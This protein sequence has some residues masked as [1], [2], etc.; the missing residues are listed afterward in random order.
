LSDDLDLD[1]VDSPK[2]ASGAYGET[3]K[4][5]PAPKVNNYSGSY[6]HTISRGK[7]SKARAVF[8]IVTDLRDAWTGPKDYRSSIIP[9]LC[10]VHACNRK[11]ID[12]A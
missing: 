6:F 11:I 10:A 9:T 2:V 12:W 5:L 3:G 4:G 1:V 7:A 8:S